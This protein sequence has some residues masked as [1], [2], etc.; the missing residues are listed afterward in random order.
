MKYVGHPRRTADGG[1]RRAAGGL[2][3]PVGSG[4]ADTPA[5]A[6]T[7]QGGIHDYAMGEGGYGHG[8]SPIGEAGNGNGLPTEP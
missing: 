4:Q 7:P 2:D 6:T 5:G 3:T 1:P 8:G